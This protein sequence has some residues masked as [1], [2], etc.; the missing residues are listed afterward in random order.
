MLSRLSIAERIA[1]VAAL[2]GVL[3]SFLTWYGYTDGALQV[4]VNGF[5][6]SLLG[7]VFFAAS[8]TVVGLVAARAR[9]ISVGRIDPRVWSACAITATASAGLQLVLTPIFGRSLH[10][11]LLLALA[12][13]LVMLW[14][15]RKHA[16]EHDIPIAAIY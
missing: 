11:G 16:G 1:G 14:T 8:A 9:L 10:S 13:A 2:V 15:V 4:S 7:D 3:A 5:R 6:A 12:T